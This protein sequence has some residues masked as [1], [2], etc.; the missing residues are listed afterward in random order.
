MLKELGRY[1]W[2]HMRTTGIEPHM[3]VVRGPALL[4]GLTELLLVSI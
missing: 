3:Q 2:A 4:V 1:Y